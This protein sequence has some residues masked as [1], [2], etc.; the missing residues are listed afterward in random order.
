MSKSPN[1]QQKLFA[2]EYLIDLN[3]TQAAIRAGYSKRTAYSQGQRL[4][5]HV[6]VKRLVLAGMKRRNA[7]I[8]CSS[9]MVLERLLLLAN[10]N[11]KK[12]MR[13]NDEQV[14]YYDFTE[15]TT[16]DWFCL[17]EITVDRLNRGKIEVALDEE[18][19]P[20]LNHVSIDRVKIKSVSKIRAL[21][22]VGRHVDV[23]AFKDKVEVDVVDRAT[24]IQKARLR[25]AQRPKKK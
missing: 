4:L 16:E 24:I 22:L 6:E 23:Q 8:E 18:G 2:K 9:D 5:K 14:P 21:E 1:A 25:A 3:A 17:E 13:F 10:F 15:A 19:N 12:F 11:L 20:C 7:K